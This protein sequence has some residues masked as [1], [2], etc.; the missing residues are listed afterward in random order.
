VAVVAAKH[1]ERYACPQCGSES[2]RPVLTLARDG[3]PPGAPGHAIV[4]NH[5]VIVLCDDCGGGFVEVMNHD[6]F[7][8]EEVFTQS[9]WFAFDRASGDVLRSALSTCAQPLDASCNCRLH[10]SLRKTTLAVK[11]WTFGLEAA[12][13]IQPIAIVLKRGVPALEFS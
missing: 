6:C 7:D 2:I 13:H 11:P 10:R 12:S 8:F 1:L 9:E 5:S 4:Y 3:E